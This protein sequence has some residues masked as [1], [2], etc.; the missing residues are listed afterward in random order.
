[1]PWLERCLTSV[2]NSSVSA[3]VFIVDNGSKDGT[4]NYIQTHFPE[5]QITCS[6]SNL[7]FGKANNLA[8]KQAYQQQFT[9]FLL[10]NQDTWLATNTIAKLTTAMDK[11]RFG[12]LSCLQ[13]QPSLSSYDVFFQ[14]YLRGVA[15]PNLEDIVREDNHLENNAPLEL[16]FINAAL[17]LLHRNTL[18]VVGGFN[19]YFQHYGE[20]NDY[21]HR[22]HYHGYQVGLLTNT[23]FVHDRPQ[24]ITEEK[25]KKLKR[26]AKEVYYMNPMLHYTQSDFKQNFRKEIV[27]RLSTFKLYPAYYSYKLFKHLHA[28][29]N[30]MMAYKQQVLQK[31]KLLF[32]QN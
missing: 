14:H 2:R 29:W 20:D 26:V 28:R 18:E 13:V 32:L 12:I 19:P 6:D 31:N 9:Y 10:L 1:M 5:V 30:E 3:T 23:Y 27:Q 21:V 11:D 7:G 25:K 15:L 8:L 22:V 17:W 24:V 4:V 16:P